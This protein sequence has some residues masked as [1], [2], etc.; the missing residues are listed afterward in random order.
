LAGETTSQRLGKLDRPILKFE[1]PTPE[2]ETV[3]CERH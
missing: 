1:H 2:L 3:N